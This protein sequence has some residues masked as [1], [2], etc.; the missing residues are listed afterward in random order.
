[1]PGIPGSSSSSREGCFFRSGGTFHSIFAAA[2]ALCEA[3][4]LAQAV[5]QRVERMEV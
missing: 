5:Q 1:M 2:D 4:K 3:R